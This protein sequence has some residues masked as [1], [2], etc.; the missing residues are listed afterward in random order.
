LT[1]QTDPPTRPTTHF[2]I[3]AA[4]LIAAFGVDTIMSSDDHMGGDSDSEDDAPAPPAA[5]P[6]VAG[7]AAMGGDVVAEV[8]AAAPPSTTFQVAGGS[9][10]APV[11]NAV[12]E[13][14]QPLHMNSRS[15]VMAETDWNVPLTAARAAAYAE[16]GPLLSAPFT[17]FGTSFRLELTPNDKSAGRGVSLRVRSMG[18]VHRVHLRSALAEIYVKK[19]AT[20]QLERSKQRRWAPPTNTVADW[21]AR[22]DMRDGTAVGW[23]PLVKQ[24]D[25]EAKERTHFIS[26]D[27]TMCLHVELYFYAASMLPNSAS[28]GQDL[29]QLRRMENT[30]DARFSLRDGRELRAHL[31]VLCARSPYFRTLAYGEHFTKMPQKDGSYDASEFDEHAFEL[32]V[33]LT[34]SDDQRILEG[35][36]AETVLEVLRIADL[37]CVDTV[38]SMCDSHLAYGATLNVYTCGT[39]LATAHRMGWSALKRAAMEFFKRNKAA[40][41]ETATFAKALESPDL[42]VEIMRHS[43]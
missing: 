21:D 40:V 31:A 26:H 3:T 38:R 24:A 11:R 6:V 5:A 18:P 32:F 34:Y 7:V 39:M 2:G 41:V 10:A 27:G 16:T 42:A 19:T 17:C 35:A 1:C 29:S 36:S 23:T 4:V 12:V 28:L 13:Q 20:E 14:P 43:V 33:N 25:L 22:V 30:C 9:A 8:A 37:Y 15:H